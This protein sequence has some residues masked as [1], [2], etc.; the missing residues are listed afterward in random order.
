LEGGCPEKARFIPNEHGISP[1]SPPYPES[2]PAK[3]GGKAA[4]RTK[5]AR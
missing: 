1:G 3:E 2:R 4:C 5:G